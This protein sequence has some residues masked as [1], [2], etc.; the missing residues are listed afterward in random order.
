[1]KDLFSSQSDQYLKYRPDYPKEFFEYLN[2]LVPKKKCAWDCG[3]GNGQ[4]ASVLSKNF[5]YVFGTDISSEQIRNSVK[6]D[7]IFYSV[8]PAE[9]TNFSDTIFDVIVVAQAI[10]WFDFDR[11]YEEVRRTSKKNAI[12]C[13]VGYARLQVSPEIDPFVTDF[14]ESTIGKY[15]AP[16]RKYIDHNYKTI[17]FPF[18]EIETPTF[19]NR[20]TWSLDHFIGYINTWSAVKEFIRQNGYNPVDQLRE[21][22]KM[23]WNIGESKKVCFPILLRVGS[24]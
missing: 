23:F 18:S 15:W 3:T 6:K 19:E 20:L 17:P 8:Q 2:S 10:H 7:N 21:K 14:Y 5:D 11:F 24:I 13:V 12:I 4:V 1:M 16:E 22:I 9:K